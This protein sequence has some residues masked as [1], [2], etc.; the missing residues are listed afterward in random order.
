MAKATAR[1]DLEITAGLVLRPGDTLIL[2][3]APP[4]SEEQAARV[5]ARVQ[6]LLPG[7]ASVVLVPFTTLAAYRPEPEDR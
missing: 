6:E 2:G 3:A 4:I 1:V 5:K 7:L